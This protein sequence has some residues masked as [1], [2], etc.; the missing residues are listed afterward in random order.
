M[1]QHRVVNFNSLRVCA[2][3]MQITACFS[4]GSEETE[5]QQ[6]RQ[7]LPDES[8]LALH[9]SLSGKAEADGYE[10][11]INIMMSPGKKVVMK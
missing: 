9:Y 4:S 6:W 3:D 7:K 2:I 11:L 8:Q 5:I 10:I 1:I